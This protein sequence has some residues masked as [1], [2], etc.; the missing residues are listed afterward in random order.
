M[1]TFR[2]RLYGEEKKNEE[3]NGLCPCL[4]ALLRAFAGCAAETPAP[5]DDTTTPVTFHIASLKGPTT[6]GIVKLMSDAEEG[7]GTLGNDYQ[8]TM[9]GTADE[10][11]PQLVN[12]DVDAALVP[13]NLASVLYAKT[14][15]AVQVAAINTLGVLY[16]V[17]TGDTVNSVADLAGKNDLQYR[18]RNDSRV[19]AEL[20][21]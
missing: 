7:T 6:I 18:K 10:I 4:T 19:C 3:K 9:Y 17:E 16:I 1:Q 2:V 11:V 15:G 14:K 13:C 5:A 20:H 8:V 21:S 12:G